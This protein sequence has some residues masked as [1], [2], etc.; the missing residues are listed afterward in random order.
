METE[1]KILAAEQ[2]A[3]IEAFK[4]RRPEFIQFYL[5]KAGI[6]NRERTASWDLV[7]A[8]IKKVLVEMKWGGFGLIG[9]Y[10]IGKSFGLVAGLGR[11]AGRVV[12][13]YT[14]K[15]IE[16]R[17]ESSARFK[18]RFSL[19]EE[20]LPIRP[21]PLWC[22]WP[23]EVAANRAK[24]YKREQQGDVEDWILNLQDAERLVIL[25]DLG[26][27]RMTAQDWTGEVLARVI[28]ERLRQDAPTIWTS[29][30]NPKELAERYGARTYS[31]LQE[32]APPIRLPDL[33]DQRLRKRPSLPSA[34]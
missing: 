32:L 14:D 6:A 34:G 25:D 19:P 5:V 2:Q 8:E 16:R 18:L 17:L 29:N 9:G 7:P 26:A 28:D 33:P 10:G 12:D 1:P 20:D 3:T 31:R 30:L 15:E 11:M 21:W 22:N 27:D 4:A 24:L 13:Q 23:G